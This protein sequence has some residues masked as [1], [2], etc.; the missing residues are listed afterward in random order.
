MKAFFKFIVVLVV[1]ALIVAGAGYAVLSFG[2]KANVDW[3]QQDLDSMMSKTGVKVSNVSD[4]TVEN[5]SSGNFKVKGTRQVDTSL[6]SEEFSAMVASANDE[7]GA[8]KD[9]RINFLD[10]GELELSFKLPPNISEIL[11]DWGV[12]DLLTKNDPGFT[13]LS[14]TGGSVISLTDSLIKYLSNLVENKPIYARG[15]LEKTGY[16]QVSVSIEEIRVGFIP[17]NRSTV[18]TVEE[19]T[20][21]FVNTFITSQNG[22]RIEELRIENGKIYYKGTLPSEIEG[23]PVS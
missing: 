17:L 18:D 22:F 9:F 10:D 16:N 14:I 11:E 1:I 19:K 6:T 5:V 8:L 20:E 2:R 4:L 13:L 3:E 23:I 21:L 15:T 12:L 7:S